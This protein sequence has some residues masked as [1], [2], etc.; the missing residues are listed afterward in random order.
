MFVEH[1]LAIAKCRLEG[2]RREHWAQ[3]AYVRASTR[4][5]R[6]IIFDSE[7]LKPNHHHIRQAVSI[8]KTSILKINRSIA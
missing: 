3:A 4:Q 2:D 1:L 8:A 7:E 6:L 5:S